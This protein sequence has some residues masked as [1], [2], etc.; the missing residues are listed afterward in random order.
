M[1][2]LLTLVLATSLALAT[3]A[4]TPEDNFEPL[5]QEVEQTLQHY[6]R[7][8]NVPQVTTVLKGTNHAA[9]ATALI[10]G[11]LDVYAED[12][13]QEGP[14][15][16]LRAIRAVLLKQMRIH[17]DMLSTYVPAELVT[18][19]DGD[20]RA[21]IEIALAEQLNLLEQSLQEFKRHQTKKS[22]E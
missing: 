22:S 8:M 11:H 17:V 4:Q 3:P 1:H 21:A 6:K 16:G 19:F 15:V 5:I 14:R 13:P 9:R 7:W 12:M 20:R 10:D 2:T 18:E